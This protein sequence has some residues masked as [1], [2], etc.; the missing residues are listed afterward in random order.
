[1]KRRSGRSV[2]L[3]PPSAFRLSQTTHFLTPPPMLWNLDPSHSSVEFAVKHMAISTVRGKFR[4]FAGTAETDE[5]GQL[6]AIT[7]T[8]DA[9]TID[10][11][12]EQRDG[13]LKSAD[14]F[15]VENHPTFTFTSTRIEHPSQDEVVVHGE[16]TMRG[17]TKPVTLTGELAAPAK[18]PWGNQRAAVEL[19]GK[20]SRKEWGLVWNT[21]LETGGVLVSDDVKLTIAAQATAAAAATA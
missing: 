17:V 20:I 6:T 16:L 3:L 9:T 13:H 4:V 15:D 12:A 21:A 10:T 8:V 11:G 7:A 18:D 19:T 14:F 1:M 2:R 5:K